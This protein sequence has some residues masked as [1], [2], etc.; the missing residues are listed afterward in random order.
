MRQG[1]ADQGTEK[2]LWAC[3]N[4]LGMD[5]TNDIINRL[6]TGAL[7]ISDVDVM[8]GRMWPRAWETPGHLHILFNAL[9]KGVNAIPHWKELETGLRSLGVFLGKR[10]LRRRLISKCCSNHAHAASVFKGWSGGNFS[11]RWEKLYVF[12]LQLRYRIK[13]LIELWD[14][15]KMSSNEANRDGGDVDVHDNSIIG[16]VTT[17]L[18]IP[19]L[20]TLVELLFVKVKAVCTEASWLEGCHCHPRRA[21]RDEDLLPGQGRKR[22][23]YE[24][25]PWAG[26]RI[27]EIAMGRSQ[28]AQTSLVGA[29]SDRLT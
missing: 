17:T 9:K 25:C 10:G 19:S 29:T 1:Y 27:V 14:S 7:N 16:R 8:R 15:D 23:D 26:R 20:E 21:D 2:D 5:G 6:R 12:L 3:P 18:A 4:I 11:W 24:R 22:G 28:H 13:L